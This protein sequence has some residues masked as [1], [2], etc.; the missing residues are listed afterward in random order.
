MLDKVPQVFD[1]LRKLK[2]FDFR[3]GRAFPEELMRSIAEICDKYVS[4]T[5]DERAEIR[6]FVTFEISFVFFK[7]SQEMAEKAVQQASE[8]YLM[9]SLVALVIEDCKFD[10]RDSSVALSKVFHSAERIGVRG[11]EFF[12]SVASISGPDMAHLLRGFAAG[13][14]SQRDISA[15]GFQEG[16]NADGLFAYV[17][18][19]RKNSVWES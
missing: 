5:D 19:I 6:S 14:P 8:T 11:K 3:G 2:V 17:P 9:Q 10:E 15:V 12:L 16:K 13:T 7:F 18:L 4:V 1:Q